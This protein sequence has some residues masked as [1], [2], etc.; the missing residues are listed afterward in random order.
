[1]DKDVTAYIL[2]H[3]LKDQFESKA[4]MARSLGVEYRSMLRVLAGLDISKAGTFILDKALLYCGMHAVSVDMILKE[5]IEKDDRLIKVLRTSG[6][7]AAM[8][9]LKIIMP[10]NLTAQGEV[11]YK[12][13]VDF[14][15]QISACVCPC[16]EKWCDPWG[17]N[18]FINRRQCFIGCT[19]RS[20]CDNVAEHFQEQ[21][22]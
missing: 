14:V 15:Q 3:L 1:M 13:L 5:F 17:V 7:Q 18:D 12:S 10:A 8:R 21:S 16:C 2:R 19:A 11:I 9:K 6:H 22:S 20:V 4:D